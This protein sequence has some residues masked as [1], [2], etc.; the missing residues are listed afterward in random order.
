[1]EDI[2]LIRSSFMR[3]IISQIINKA[4]KKQAPGVEVELK[5]AQVNWVD[6]EQK[7]RVHLELDAAAGDGVKLIRHVMDQQAV[8]AVLSAV[9]GNDEGVGVALGVVHRAVQ[10][11]LDVVI[12]HALNGAGACAGAGDPGKN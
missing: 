4:L 5:E 12:R 6:K 9:G 7:L 3:R 10:F 8:H 2:M 1:M 11:R